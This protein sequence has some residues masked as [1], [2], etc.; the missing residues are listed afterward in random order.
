MKGNF[1]RKRVGMVFVF[2]I[3]LSFWL[4]PLQTGSGG[5]LPEGP[6]VQIGAP[7]ISVEDKTMTIDAGQFD[8]TWIDWTG[9]F[10]IGVE[11][12]VNN[13]GPSATAVILHNDI[14]GAISNIAGV[15]NANCNIFLLNA[16]GILFSP[17]AQVNVGGLVASSL[18]MKKEDFLAGNY[19]L[20]GA[21]VVT[22]NNNLAQIVNQG[23]LNAGAGG[24]TLAGGA[25]KN[26]GTINANLSTVNLVSG[27]EVALNISSDGNI[28]A[29]VTKEILD[30]V[31]DKD[32]NKVNIGVENLGEINAKGGKIYIET[33]AVKDVFD[34]LINQKGIV[35]AGSIVEKEGKIILVSDSEGI[36]QNTGTL[37]ASAMEAGAK[38]GSIEMT[39]SK[40][41]QFGTAKADAIDGDGGS[42]MLYANDVVALSS[43]SITSANAGIN[44]D[45]GTIIVYSPETANFWEGARIEAKGGS[46]SG[47]GGFVEVSGKEFMRFEG[48]VDTT[49]A[50]GVAG[51][52][53][54]D[55]KNITVDDSGSPTLL[56]DV[57]QFA[58]GGGANDAVLDVDTL[59]AAVANVTLQANNDITI[60]N[61]DATAKDVNIATAGVTLTM[62]A[63]RSIIINDNIITNNAAITITANET[64]ANGVQN[65]NRDA[66]AATITLAD[67][68]TINAGNANITIT[69]STGAGLT[70][71]TSG[72]ITLE[73]LTTT[74]HVLIVN[75][76]PTAG[77]GILR[78]SDDALIT[79]SSVALDV[80]GAGG[81][82][83][84][85]TSAAPIRVTVTNLEARGQ[86]GGVYI[87]SP[88]QGLTLGGATLGGLTGISTSSN[89]AISVVVPTAGNITTSEAISANG[90]G[91]V[92]LD[93]QAA[94]ATITI[95]ALGDVDSGSGLI[96]LLADGDINLNAGGTVGAATTGA[97]TI[98]ADQDG[99]AAG[100]L[101]A[102]AN[103]GNASCAGAITIT[104]ADI[105]LA[106]TLDGTGAV[107]IQPST[108]TRTI[109]IGDLAAGDFS[110]NVTDISNINDGFSSITIGRADTNA[111]ITINPITFNDPVTI[112]APSGGTL[113]VNGKITG[114]GNASITLD[115]SGATTILN[116]DIITAGNPI[117]IS[118]NVL[119]DDDAGTGILLDTTNG[120]ASAAANVS[121]TGTVDSVALENNSLTIDADSALGK[122]DVTIGG[123]IGSSQALSALTITGND[124][125][126]ASIG[127]AAA[128]VTGATSITG[129]DIVGDA[130]TITL[131]GTTYNAN[132]QTYTAGATGN[133]SLT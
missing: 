92:T 106:A 12:T 3:G 83:E 17:T 47:N 112:R 118:D 127:G 44:G 34:T 86:S 96:S 121:I 58:D 54:I 57:D 111:N 23:V 41:G 89:G 132:Q 27:K 128:G 103:I 7:T 36:V 66:G 65:A 82:G 56:T 116:A 20:S 81:G 48:I 105:A 88:T 31:Y 5:D 104:A 71:N 16:N 4:I 40:V 14:S 53:L 100:S 74:G 42:I 67:G 108:T 18:M 91:T 37:D 125:T 70:N 63:G 119:I 1:L 22:L 39:G 32:G 9:G 13:L 107:T 68:K 98:T 61:M 6:Q 11:N 69:L 49:A 129:T 21:D 124:I 28:S 110:L 55:P 131:T 84:I 75:N 59:N 85:G 8:K 99:D 19:V 94:A 109:G 133:I 15:L 72:D 33:E 24:I 95:G 30:N 113:T 46:Q 120:G 79:A 122:A 43:G 35:R 26:S 78:T 45:G 64:V 114:S 130:A 102:L 25:I 73:N 97:I 76:G 80:N 62:Q 126:I 115:G 87:N 51:T 60:T 93:A 90:T 101:N 117:T 77:S 50:N 52:L 29:K 10:N 2:F 123:A 38:G